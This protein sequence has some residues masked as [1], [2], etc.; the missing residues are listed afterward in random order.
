[1]KTIQK[2]VYVA[3]DLSEFT[4]LEDCQKHEAALVAKE[5][6]LNDLKL[7]RVAWAFEAT[8]GRGYFNI[9]NIITDFEF[10]S[11]E[12]LNYC[13]GRYG[14]PLRCWYGKNYYAEW[15]LDKVESDISDHIKSALKNNGAF[16]KNSSLSGGKIDTVFISKKEAPT[17]EL[18]KISAPFFK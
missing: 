14:Q 13:I 6:L 12:I 7:Y 11:P 4:K 10:N 5:K 1:M 18:L 2:T 3:E 15:K 17:D 16:R 8:E 9:T